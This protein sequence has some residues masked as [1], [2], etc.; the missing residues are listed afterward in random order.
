MALLLV[1]LLLLLGLWGL[2]QTCTRTPSPAPRWPP[3]PR[4]LPLI[5]NLHLLRVS[6]QDQSLMEVGQGRPPGQPSPTSG[7]VELVFQAPRGEG[8]PVPAWVG[9][10]THPAL[11]KRKT[12]HPMG[13]QMGQSRSRV[14]GASGQEGSLE[15]AAF[16]E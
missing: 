4:P 5:G 9:P 10:R 16:D 2:L 15:E 8:V 3:G 6:Q 11:G 12:A 13:K 7:E 1:G 14:P